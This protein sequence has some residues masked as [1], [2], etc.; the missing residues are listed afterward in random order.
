MTKEEQKV[1]N[2][3]LSKLFKLDSETVASLYN[4]AGE[5]TDFSKILELDRERIQK[6]KDDND[7]Q[8]KRGV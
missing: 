8:Y 7:S 5:L 4:E 6:Y 1:L 3:S 2:E